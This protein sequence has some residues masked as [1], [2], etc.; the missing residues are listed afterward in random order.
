MPEKKARKKRRKPEDL[1]EREKAFVREFALTCDIQEAQ[2]AVGYAPHTGNGR[3]ILNDPRA[4]VL[5]KQLL[6]RADELAEIHLA[7]VKANI[8]RLAGFNIYDILK[9][10][11]DGSVFLDE[12]G[13][14]HLDPQKLTREQMYAISEFGFDADGRMKFKLHDKLAA[15]KVLHEDLAPEKP[16]RM[17]L[18]G[19]DGGP[20]EVIDGLAA[21]LNAARQRFKDRRSGTG[22]AG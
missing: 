18:E 14:W 9:H 8:K 5:L 19:K 21:R 10:N 15:N 3:R 1:N 6:K 13:H 2:R 22:T 20:I 16:Q 11:D 4:Q 7:W 12:H 17:R